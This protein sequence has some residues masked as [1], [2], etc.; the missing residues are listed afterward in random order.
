MRVT[1]RFAKTLAVAALPLA[2]AACSTG[3]D[4]SAKPEKA[5]K[6]ADPNAGLLTGTQL[7]AALPKSVTPAS[8]LPVKGGSPDSGDDFMDQSPRSTAKPKCSD[9]ESNAW[10]SLSGYQGGVSFAQGDF[11]NKAQT[12]EIADEIDAF[13]GETAKSVMKG[14]RDAVAACPTFT[15]TD[16][17]AQVKAEGHA[18]P[19]LGDE[20]YTIRLTSPRFENGSTLV[21]ARVGNSVATVM[22]TAGNDDGAATA[23]AVIT[24][25]VDAL[26]AKAAKS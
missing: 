9:F 25:I 8:L 5:A 3:T 11:V 16:A 23:G 19:G 15:D 13:Q 4:S 6:A 14:I 26:K 17:H 20:A 22:S 21:A 24:H 18:A 1:S 12:E 7:K 10:P 2:L